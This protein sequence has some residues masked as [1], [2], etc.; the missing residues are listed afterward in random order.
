LFFYFLFF[1]GTTYI[2]WQWQPPVIDGGLAITDYEISYLAKHTTFDTQKG[3]YRHWEEEVS[4]LT[5]MFCFQHN[6]IAHT[7]F[8]LCGLRAGSEYTN[9][10]LRCCNLRGWSEWEEMLRDEEDPLTKLMRSQ[11]RLANSGNDGVFTLESGG[12]SS[13]AHGA[14]G[15]GGSVASSGAGAAEAVGGKKP[16]PGAE[17][18][19]ERQLRLRL[20]VGRKVSTYEP[21]QP[22]VPLFVNCYKITSSCI[23]IEWSAPFYDGGVPITNYWVHYTVMERQ[24]TVTA[25]D[26]VFE[27]PHKFALEGPYPTEAVIRNIP[28][29]TDVIR[30]YVIAVNEV[31]LMSEKGLL[32]QTLCHTIETS[33]HGQLRREL[34]LAAAATEPFFDSAFFTVSLSSS[35]IVGCP[36]ISYSFLL[37]GCFILMAGSAATPQQSR[38]FEA[39]NRRIVNYAS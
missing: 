37:F 12:E 14:G 16:P 9:F 30:I 29:N 4:Q 8:R 34:A 3:K 13:G 36:S 38:A 33:R 25:R 2:D 39:I 1:I 26:V 27:Q 5:T 23:H 35:V 15:G 32:K 31:G 19:G 24:V 21:E 6:A 28:P 10:R 18:F 20:N 7:E 11:Q 22:S 17:T